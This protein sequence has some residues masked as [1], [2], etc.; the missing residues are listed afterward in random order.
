MRE[1]KGYKAKCKQFYWSPYKSHFQLVVKEFISRCSYLNVEPF[2][3]SGN[4]LR[5]NAMW[6]YSESRLW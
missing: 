1:Q 3:F 4:G 6:I 5:L 2:L